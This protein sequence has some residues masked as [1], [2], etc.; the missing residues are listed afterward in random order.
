MGIWLV[1]LAIANSFTARAFEFEQPAARNLSVDSV[2]SFLA[3]KVP[4][5]SFSTRPIIVAAALVE[6][7]WE[8][9][10]EAREEKFD[11][12]LLFASPIVTTEPLPDLAPI[13]QSPARSITTSNLGLISIMWE[14]IFRALGRVLDTNRRLSA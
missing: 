4:P 10:E 1:E 8:R 6:S 2:A 11:S 9:I 14:A 13:V 5:Q 12:R 3:C 7:C